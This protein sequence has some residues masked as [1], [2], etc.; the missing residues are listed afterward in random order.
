[1][2]DADALGALR[3]SVLVKL[4]FGRSGERV[5]AADGDEDVDPQRA[6]RVIDGLH[7]SGGLRVGQVFRFAHGF[8]RVG[9]CGTDDDPAFG[10]AAFEVHFVEAEVSHAFGQNVTVFVLDEMGVTVE[11]A[12]NFDPGAA[13]AVGCGA[14]HGV[15]GRSRAAGE[16]NTNLF[17]VGFDDLG[18]FQ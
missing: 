8:A 16:Q 10:A 9:S 5:V 14:D 1:M 15:G 4:E 7:R 3:E 13:E 6:E 11:E 2:D 17:D 12:V 18:A